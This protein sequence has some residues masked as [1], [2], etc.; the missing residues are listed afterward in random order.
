MF[1]SGADETAC[2]LVLQYHTVLVEI[3][4]CN[5]QLNKNSQRCRTFRTEYALKLDAL[6]KRIKQE[7]SSNSI[8]EDIESSDEEGELIFASKGSIDAS[9]ITYSIT[10]A[11]GIAFLSL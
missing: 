4:R 9:K 5:T 11:H 6:N 8:E 2:S 10:D 1:F 7:V 3:N